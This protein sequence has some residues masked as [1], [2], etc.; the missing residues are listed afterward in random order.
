MAEKRSIK[1]KDESQLYQGS[2]DLNEWITKA[3]KIQKIQQVKH[4]RGRHL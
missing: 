3:E 4:R 1:F 2:K